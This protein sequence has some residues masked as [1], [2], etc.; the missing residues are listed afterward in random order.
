[1]SY[2]FTG[3]SAIVTGGAR[4]I[5]R[6]IADM[7]AAAGAEVTV[8]DLAEPE[9]REV[10]RVTHLAV[11][12]TSSAAVEAAVAGL[13]KAPALLVNNAGITRDKSLWKMNDEEWR[14]VIDVNLGGAF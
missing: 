2:D 11:D 7:L 12:I 6:V 3:K 5:G 13:P 4:G 1:M 9:T 14:A 10:P 8:F